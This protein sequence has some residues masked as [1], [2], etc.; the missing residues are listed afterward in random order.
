MEAFFTR[1]RANEGARLDLTLPDGTPTEDF[2]MIR[3][4][5][6]DA[7]RDAL[8]AMNKRVL[9]LSKDPNV[10]DK[11]RGVFA[12]ETD[13]LVGSLIISWSFEDPVNDETIAKLFKE[14]PQIRNS[15]DALATKRSLFFRKTST[16]S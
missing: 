5:D 16:P 10:R 9:E 13:K 12:D 8:Q 15:I 4:V 2:I 6:S 3:G 7:Y 1:Q 11:A 14:A